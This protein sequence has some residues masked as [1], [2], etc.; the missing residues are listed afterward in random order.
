MDEEEEAAEERRHMRTIWV[1]GRKCLTDREAAALIVEEA[2]MILQQDL[3]EMGVQW[4]LHSLLN[5]DTQSSP[6]SESEV[7]EQKFVPQTNGSC[8]RLTLKKKSNLMFS[9][10]FM[11]AKIFKH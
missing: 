10:S 7:K 1:T 8:K 2:K 4:N 6:S 3:V 11:H 5:S 9:D